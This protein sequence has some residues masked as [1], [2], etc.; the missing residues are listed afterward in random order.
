MKEEDREIT[1]KLGEYQRMQAVIKA[2][3]EHIRQLEHAILAVH[4]AGMHSKTGHAYYE[5]RREW[6]ANEDLQVE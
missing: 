4:S 6:I 3:S 5:T 2:A 1:I